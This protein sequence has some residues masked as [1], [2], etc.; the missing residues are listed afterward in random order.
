[1]KY[2]INVAKPKNSREEWLYGKGGYVHYFKVEV[3][4]GKVKEVY[5]KLCEVFPDCDITVTQWETI[6]K[7]IDMT[8]CDF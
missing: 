1:M 5:Q 6:G 2:E 3:E 8:N 4:Y 7:E